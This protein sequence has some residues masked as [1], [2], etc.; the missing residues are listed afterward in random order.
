MWSIAYPFTK[1]DA[2]TSLEIY[3]GNHRQLETRAPMYAFVPYTIN[4]EP[5]IIGGY[6]SRRL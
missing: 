2:G 4:N 3:H 6:L 5:Y 1:A